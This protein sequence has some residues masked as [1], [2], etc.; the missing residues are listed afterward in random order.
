MTGDQRIARGDRSTEPATLAGLVAA[1]TDRD[2]GGLALIERDRDQFVSLTFAE[3]SAAVAALAG[4][5]RSRG[6]VRGDVIGVWLPNW[7]EMIVW[8]FALASLGAATL[9]INTRYGVNEITHLIER[10]RPTGMVAPAR[11]LEL[12]FTGRLRRASA[13]AGGSD[14]PWVAVVRAT[15]EDDVTGFDI[16][17]GAWAVPPL[18]E[19]VGCRE[20]IPAAGRPQDPVNYFTTSGSTGMPKLAGHDQASV[21]LH[22]ANVAKALEIRAGDRFL[23]VLPLSGVFG[24]NPV[25]AT[26]GVGGTCLLE[27]IF[28]PP[29]ILDD[30][31]LHEITHLVGGDDMLGRLM[32]AWHARPIRER[33]ALRRV[34]RGAIADFAG[35]VGAVVEWA[36]GFGAAIGGAY[37]SS[38]LFSLTATWPPSLELADRARAGG[39]LLSSQISVRVIDP[40]SG[41]ICPPGVTGELQFQGYNVVCG[42]LGDPDGIPRTFSDDGWFRSGD[43]GFLLEQPESFIYVCR[44]GDALRL[45]GFLVEPAEIEQFLCSHPA[46]ATAKVVGVGSPGSSDV[47]VAYVQLAGGCATSEEELIAFCRDQ[48]APFKVPAHIN[49]IDAFPTTTGTNGTKIVTAEL[50]R[51][52]E[53]QLAQA[54]QV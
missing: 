51:R 46:I 33:P 30:V 24:F 12:D 18:R 38:E 31:E 47:A 27:P 54:R 35:R 16:G 20:P 39:T 11:F 45:R 53:R 23:S 42:Y 50:R 9:G 36:D 41:S 26:L 1:A 43:L 52:A 19:L 3:L 37:G 40:E 49:V 15:A 34:R 14:Q 48:L 13:D 5:L 17:G 29:Q 32:D 28:E 22:G 21:V 4:E 10:G 2:G 7:I 44:A 25:I 8:E 6:V